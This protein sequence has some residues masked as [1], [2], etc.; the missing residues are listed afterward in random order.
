MLTLFVNAGYASHSL[1]GPIS[2]LFYLAPLCITYYSQRASV[3]RSIFPPI[4]GA[5]T[6]F[7]FTWC[8]LHDPLSSHASLFST[9]MHFHL[10][11]HIHSLLALLSSLC[12]LSQPLSCPP[13]IHSALHFFFINSYSVALFAIT[14]ESPFTPEISTFFRARSILIDPWTSPQPSV[15]LLSPLWPLLSLPVP[16][17]SIHFKFLSSLLNISFDSSF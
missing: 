10:R 6:S 1:S 2:Q 16:Y 5:P 8:M 13:H 7:P 9:A 15:F 12:F 11:F 4:R 3:R 14:V 17:R